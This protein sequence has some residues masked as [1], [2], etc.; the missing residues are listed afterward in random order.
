MNP[1]IMSETVAIVTEKPC[2]KSRR[3]TDSA[4]VIG[5]AYF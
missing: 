5:H 4:F 3:N 2:R 1:L